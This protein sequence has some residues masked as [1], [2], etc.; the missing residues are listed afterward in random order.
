MISSVGEFEKSQ[1]NSIANS[2]YNFL[3][4]LPAPLIY[5]MVA[6]VMTESFDAP[7]SKIPMAVLL[8]ST[9]F[10]VGLAF[11]GLNLRISHYQELDNAQASM[12]AAED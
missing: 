7:K 5:G 9:L 11:Y 3:G 6:Q 1:A 4:Y 12:L 8:Y 10:T 2:A